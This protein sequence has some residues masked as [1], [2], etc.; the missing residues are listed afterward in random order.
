MPTVTLNVPAVIVDVA[1]ARTV[2]EEQR[3]PDEAPESDLWVSREGTFDGHRDI[4]FADDI[5][6]V[7]T[8]RPMFGPG[9]TFDFAWVK[10]IDSSVADGIVALLSFDDVP[11]VYLAP[12]TTIWVAELTTD[13]EAVGVDQAIAIYEA[14]GGH[15]QR[16]MD[17]LTA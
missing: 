5:L 13:N 1:A 17:S 8:W 10:D 14:V 16:M 3:Q 15:L 4:G 2:F 12:S 6:R 11:G 9:I 7:M